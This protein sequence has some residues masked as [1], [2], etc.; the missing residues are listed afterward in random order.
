MNYESFG[1]MKQQLSYNIVRG[2]F[3]PLFQ[4]CQTTKI[5]NLKL[6]FWNSTFKVVSFTWEINPD[7]KCSV[8]LCS[9]FLLL[10]FSS[11]ILPIKTCFE[12]SCSNKTQNVSQSFTSCTPFVCEKLLRNSVFFVKTVGAQSAQDNPF[13]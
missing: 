6:S 4:V 8:Q 9:F 7:L 1:N 13:Y 11:V 10:P 2:L 3:P 12:R 5:P